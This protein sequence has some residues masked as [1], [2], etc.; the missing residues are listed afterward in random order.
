MRNILSRVGESSQGFV[1]ATL[2]HVFAPASRKDAREAMSRAIALVEDNL[3]GLQ[4][5]C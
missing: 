1:A 3:T 2:E 5:A 4:L